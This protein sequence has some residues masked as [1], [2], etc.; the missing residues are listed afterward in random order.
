MTTNTKDSKAFLI[1]GQL[2][3]QIRKQQ[4]RLNEINAMRNAN[5]REITEKDY[6]AAFYSCNGA[7]TQLMICLT[8]YDN[9]LSNFIHKEEVER[10]KQEEKLGKKKKNK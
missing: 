2:L 4:K 10:K 5:P 3:H 6:W 1:E 9:P 8:A 7:I